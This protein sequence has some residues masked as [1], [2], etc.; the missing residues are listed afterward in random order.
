MVWKGVKDSQKK[1]MLSSDLLQVQVTQISSYK[2]LWCLI[3]E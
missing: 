3:V 1:L 2:E